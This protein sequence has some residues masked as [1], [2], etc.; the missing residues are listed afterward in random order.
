M[1]AP[2]RRGACPALTAPMPTGDGLL[3]R[4]APAGGMR[5]DTFAALCAAARADGSGIV[6]VT[7]RGSIQVRGLTSIS[8][9]AFAETV[10]SLDIDGSAGVPVMIDPLAGL[11]PDQSVDASLLA[12]RLRLAL[13]AAPFAA[14]LSPKVSVLVD[15]G[16]ALH[17]DAVAADVRMRAEGRPGSARFHIA[18]GGS[19]ATATPIGAVTHVHAVEAVLQLLAVIAARGREARA[20]HIIQAEGA[21]AFRAAFAELTDAPA[22]PARAAAEP[23]GT[24]P[25]GDG[26][27]ALGIGLAFGHS[28]AA[29]LRKLVE[30]A[31]AAAAH[32]IRAAPPRALL[33]IGIEPEMAPV[34][35][36]TAESLGF[37]VAADDPR[38]HVAACSGAPFCASA[39]IATRVLAPAV[40]AVAAPLLDGSLTIHLSGCPKGCAHAGRAALT[41][42]GEKNGCGVVLNGQAGDTPMGRVMADALAESLAA[43]A[44]EVERDRRPGERAVEPLSRLSGARIAAL[45]QEAGHG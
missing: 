16:H 10:A 43:V 29:A 44:H 5:L 7:T 21:G 34:L 36:A 23:I 39:A 8:A 4:L 12:A 33:V 24:F 25:L 31:H 45:L 20:R 35:A 22:P 18:I 3:V 32:E 42:V 15:G 28:D 13:A 27:T 38:R 11:A 17:L 19:A 30:A 1:N 2:P 37:I 14:E 26:R 6:E 40:A 41:I 9:Q